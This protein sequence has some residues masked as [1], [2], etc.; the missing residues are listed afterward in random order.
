[1]SK[2]VVDISPNDKIATITFTRDAT[3]NAITKEDYDAFAIALR[4]IDANPDVLVTVWQGKWF[5]AGTDVKS[6]EATAPTLRH[7]FLQ[8]VAA[9]NT[10]TSHALYTH[11]K[12]LVAALNGP[13]IAFLGNFDFIYCMENA[14]LSVPF[15]FLGLVTEGGSS[16]SFV[17]RMGVAKANETLI[18]GKKQTS[19]DL[20]ACGFVNQIFPQQDVASFHRAVR[21]L[22]LSELS[23]LVPSSVL[24]V[25][26]L[27]KTGL[28][29]KN[30]PDAV[31]LR[32]SFEQAA[33]LHSGIPAERFHK[34]STKKIRH[35]L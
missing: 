13:V 23:D 30:D 11:S 3:L 22:L 9:A 5:C 19:R 21:D 26:K 15:A 10:E 1:M 17:N 32:E 34:I 8:R 28:R 27:I 29:E 16:V 35:K 24:A 6:R 7:N 25:K 31:N 2:V 4:E 20:L 18:W 14:W 12:I 33:R